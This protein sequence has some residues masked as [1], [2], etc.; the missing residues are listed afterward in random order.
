MEL[1][2][3]NKEFLFVNHEKATGQILQASLKETKNLKH[4]N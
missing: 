4:K 3:F 2:N 1:F